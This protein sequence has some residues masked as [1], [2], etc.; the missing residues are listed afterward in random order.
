MSKRVL[1]GLIA[2]GAGLIIIFIGFVLGR[3]D[4][5][6]FG[7]KA[8]YNRVEKTYVCTSDINDLVANESDIDI[9]IGTG[10]VDK[11][12]IRYFVDEEMEKVNIAEK[13][14]RLTFD[15]EN[16]KMFSFNIGFE[17][18]SYDTEIILPESFNGRAVIGTTSGTI[19]AEDIKGTG[20]VLKANSGSVKARRIEAEDLTVTTTSGHITLDRAEVKNR[21]D[22]ENSSGG[23][24]ANNIECEDIKIKTTSGSIKS[25][26]ITAE[27]AE[28]NSSSGSITAKE[29]KVDKKMQMHATSGS[30]HVYDSKIGI[31]KSENSS[32]SHTYN[33]VTVDEISAEASS[34]GIQMEKLDIKKTGNF[35]T[36]SGS[37][38]GSIE[39]KE[40]DFSVLVDNTSGSSNLKNSRSGEKTLDIS[41][42][43]GS[44]RISFTD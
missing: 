14:G 13:D 3:G 9:V 36:T 22:L 43:S 28:L 8:S 17:L 29:Y 30:F 33:K 15:R 23:I 19:E 6:V 38:H 18:K 27:N 11:I 42:T 24:G 12:T 10:N 5:M 26:E 40:S 31:L 35:K 1:Y 32:G 2:C 41:T 16:R 37:V 20:V 44:T 39:G 4:N 34:G 21:V 7:K 25:E